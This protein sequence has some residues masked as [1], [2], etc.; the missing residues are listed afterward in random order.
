MATGPPKV[1][2]IHVSRYISLSSKTL[3]YNE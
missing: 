3:D 1:S 2:I